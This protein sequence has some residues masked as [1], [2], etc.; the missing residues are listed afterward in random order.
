M[1]SWFTGVK[2]GKVYAVTTGQYVGQM[3]CFVEKKDGK[4]G[5]LSIPTMKNHW[6]DIKEFDH[7]ID[8]K[9]IEFVEKIPSEIKKVTKAQFQKNETGV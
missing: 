2:F 6:L 5:F 4:Y 9:I 1:K 3:L 8:N 7:A